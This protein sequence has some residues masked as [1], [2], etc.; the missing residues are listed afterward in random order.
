MKVFRVKDHYILEVPAAQKADV[1][2]L[3]AYRGLTYSTSASTR[4]KA[5]LFTDNPYAVA[6]IAQP[7]Q[8]FDL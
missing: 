2:S 3:M 5:V 7:L 4:E 8:E 6:D 1:A